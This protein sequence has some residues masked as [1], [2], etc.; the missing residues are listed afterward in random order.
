MKLGQDIGHRLRAYAAGW[1]ALLGLW[2][3]VVAHVALRAG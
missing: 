2:G 3:H 1:I